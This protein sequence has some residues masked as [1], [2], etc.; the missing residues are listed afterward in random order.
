MEGR[1]PE[2]AI[3]RRSWLDW[4]LVG[5]A[6]LLFAALGAMAQIPHMEIQMGWL[7]ALS[8]AMLGVLVVGGVVLWRVTKFS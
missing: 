8:L 1:E 4:L 7:I 3:T 2:S 5:G 6:V